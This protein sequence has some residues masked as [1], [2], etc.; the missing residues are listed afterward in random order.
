MALWADR[1]DSFAAYPRVRASFAFAVIYVLGDTF[2]HRGIPIWV[3]ITE[4][5]A[6]MRR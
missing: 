5:G 2:S 6:P 3:G 1:G 4:V